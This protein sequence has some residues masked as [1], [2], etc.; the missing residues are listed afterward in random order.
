MNFAA[1]HIDYVVASYGATAI[2]F[3]VLVLAILRRDRRLKRELARLERGAS[4][5]Q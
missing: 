1:A 4:R 3:A 5:D 2:A